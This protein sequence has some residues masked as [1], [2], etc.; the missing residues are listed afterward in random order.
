MLTGKVMQS[1]MELP[2]GVSFLIALAKAMGGTTYPV[3]QFRGK[4]WGFEVASYIRDGEM[5]RDVSSDIPSDSSLGS[6]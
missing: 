5:R 1:G 3:S 2:S 6:W 4:V